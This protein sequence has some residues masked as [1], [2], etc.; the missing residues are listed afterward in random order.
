MCVLYTFIIRNVLLCV[1][2]IYE[3]THK[4]YTVIFST[5][6]DSKVEYI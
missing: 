3:I 4:V 1:C 5:I 6:Y 2:G